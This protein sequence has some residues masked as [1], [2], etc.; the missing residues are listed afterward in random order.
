M[1]KVIV[2]ASRPRFWLYLAGPYLFG[3][4]FAYDHAQTFLTFESV[5][6]FFY[7]LIPANVFLYCINDL[8]D[9][10]SDALNPK[11]NSKEQKADAANI[12]IYYYAVTLSLVALIPIFYYQTLLSNLFLILF[13]ILSFFYSAP[14][15]RFK[16]HPFIDS[17]S[18][19]LYALPAL[20]GYIQLQNNLPRAEAIATAWLWTAAMHLFSAIPDIEYDKKALINT[21]AVTLGRKKSLLLCFLL[22][23]LM[24]II[25]TSYSILLS[26]SFIY[27]LSVLAVIF[28]FI[29]LNSMYWKY[30]YIT[31]VLGF[32]LYI[33][34][35][36]A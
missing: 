17:A 3:Y 13:L 15:F 14:P 24:A 20:I 23:L 11:K 28:G 21:T 32:L 16:A 4:T 6:T 35:Y 9:R 18:N 12:Q 36:N 19:I 2:K 5:Y 1:L 31:T 27:P 7:F 33:Y 26:P 22:W 25:S 29:S 8:F 30:P 10:P 34:A